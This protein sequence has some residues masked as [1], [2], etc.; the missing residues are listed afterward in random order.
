MTLEKKWTP[1]K[2]NRNNWKEKQF[3]LDIRIKITVRIKKRWNIKI[4][5]GKKI[6]SFKTA[7]E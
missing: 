7:R 2:F 6:R 1:I 5:N 3:Y 4:K